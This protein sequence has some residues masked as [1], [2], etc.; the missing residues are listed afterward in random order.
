MP[1]TL[2]M[3]ALVTREKVYGSCAKSNCCKTAVIHREARVQNVQK[4]SWVQNDRTMRRAKVTQTMPC[5]IL[6]MLR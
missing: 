2:V 6:R 3:T 5:G 1:L 4:A